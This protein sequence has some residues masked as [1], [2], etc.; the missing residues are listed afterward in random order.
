MI[1]TPKMRVKLGKATFNRPRVTVAGGA[2][3]AHSGS[4]GAEEIRS[5]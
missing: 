5:A 2:I 4:A 3:R 1:D